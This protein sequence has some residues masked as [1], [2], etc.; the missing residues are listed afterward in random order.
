MPLPVAWLMSLQV[1]TYV[2]NPPFAYGYIRSVSSSVCSRPQLC[3]VSC[4]AISAT[5]LQLCGNVSE[6]WLRLRPSHATFATP[7]TPGPWFE[8][9]PIT[10]IVYGS[11][12]GGRFADITML[13]GS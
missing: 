9:P 1:S 8:A 3:E 7:Q 5:P 4:A 10:A 2:L 13:N 12:S 11:Q 6:T